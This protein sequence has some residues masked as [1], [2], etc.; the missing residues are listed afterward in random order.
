MSKRRWFLWCVAGAL[1]L[2]IAHAGAV[3]AEENAE[4]VVARLLG[5]RPGALSTP[6][7]SGGF[8]VRVV[9]SGE[10][11]L[12]VRACQDGAVEFAVANDEGMPFF[13]L[14]DGRAFAYDIADDVVY[15]F[16]V[17]G[18]Q[19]GAELIRSDEGYTINSP[20]GFV[21]P[22]SELRSQVDV[23]FHSFFARPYDELVVKELGGGRVRILG[24]AGRPDGSSVELKAVLRQGDGFPY[25]SVETF[26]IKDDKRS[27]VVAL[28]PVV[29][30]EDRSGF[31]GFP[32]NLDLTGIEVAEYVPS[33]GE[34]ESGLLL[35][36]KRLLVRAMNYAEITSEAKRPLLKAEMLQRYA[37][38]KLGFE[39]VGLFPL[40]LVKPAEAGKSET[41]GESD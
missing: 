32:E 17:P 30:V 8:S 10:T 22:D 20:L 35:V 31:G 4:D 41:P 40:E 18:I 6:V 27:P 9:L 1:A 23:D 12:T 39:A 19:F 7:A 16:D 11:Y 24:T 37:L 21:G 29:L 38:A 3:G 33:Q 13:Y 25:E 26:V 15:V 34:P 5:D 36:A 14:A 28:G 2:F